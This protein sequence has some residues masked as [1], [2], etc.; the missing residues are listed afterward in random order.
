MRS[1]DIPVKPSMP[2]TIET[3][4]KISAPSTTA[5]VLLT[6]SRNPALPHTFSEQFRQIP[7]T[8]MPAPV[9]SVHLTI[10]KID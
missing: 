2:A 7:V 10:Y 4:K 9:A 8:E 3:R 5:L 6:I 1:A